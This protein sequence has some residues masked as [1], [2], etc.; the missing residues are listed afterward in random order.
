MHTDYSMLF[1]KKNEV[2]TFHLEFK[3]ARDML[4]K[5]AW[6]PPKAKKRQ[7]CVH[8]LQKGMPLI[9]PTRHCILRRWCTISTLR[10]CAIL[11]LGNL[12]PFWNAGILEELYRI[13]IESS[14]FS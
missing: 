13:F 9:D 5:E 11:A 7:S 3:Y 6:R 14:S 12:G 2:V 8:G 4:F 10:I 1:K